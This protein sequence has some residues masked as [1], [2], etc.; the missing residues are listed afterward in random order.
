MIYLFQFWLSTTKKHCDN[1]KAES[2]P[3]NTD[4]VFETV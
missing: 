3:K 1:I 4:L 2:D